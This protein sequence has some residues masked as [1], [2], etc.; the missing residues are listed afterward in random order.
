[1]TSELGVK[2]VLVADDDEDIRRL[3]MAIMSQYGCEVVGAED[4]Q[5]LIDVALREKPDLMIVDVVLPVY[6]G[7]DAMAI[8]VNEKNFSCPVLFYS[9]VAK[10]ITLYRAHKPK[11]PSA[12]MLK[13]F[14]EGE[15]I[16]QIRALMDQV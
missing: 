7:Y 4:G 13:P 12:F 1:M 10:D 5:E 11:C 3:T 6:S 14:T 2:K 9:A 15:M 16:E 8:L